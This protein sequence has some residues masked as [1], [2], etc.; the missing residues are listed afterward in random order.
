MNGESIGLREANSVI[1]V[2][3]VPAFTRYSA[4]TRKRAGGERE[5]RLP[6]HKDGYPPQTAGMTPGVL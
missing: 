3:L 1:P 6:S 5:S 4:S 2:K